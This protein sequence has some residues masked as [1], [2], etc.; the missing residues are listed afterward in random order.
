MK[1]EIEAVFLNIDKEKIRAKLQSHGAKLIAPER[2]MVRTMFFTFLQIQAT[3]LRV[4][5][6][7]VTG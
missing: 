6:T 7:R 4:Y 3:V 2:K 1:L 5:A